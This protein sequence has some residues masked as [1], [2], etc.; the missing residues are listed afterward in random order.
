[1]ADTPPTYDVV[2][3]GTGIAGAILAKELGS[4]GHSV[5]LLEAGVAI[6]NGREALVEKFFLDT[7][8]LPESPFPPNH[9]APT[10]TV[11]DLLDDVRNP[12]KGYLDQSTSKIPFGSSYERRAGGTMWHWMGTSLRL[13]PRDFRMR[14]IY[15]QGVDWPMS[16][17][18]LAIKPRSQHGGMSYYDAA[19]YEIGVAASVDDQKIDEKNLVINPGDVLYR[20]SYGYPMPAIPISTVDQ[21]FK[22]GVRGMTFDGKPVWHYSTPAGRNS[23]PYK[24]RRACA[25]NTNCVP[26]C[27][28]QAKY[29]PTVTLFA[30]LNYQGVFAQFQS[31][32]TRL[33]VKPDGSE[34]EAVEYF[35]YDE[36]REKPVRPPQRAYGRKIVVA[37]HG[38]ETPRLLLLSGAGNKYFKNPHIGKHLMDHPFYI[39]W[40]LAPKPVYPHRGPLSTGGLDGLRDGAFRRDRAAFRIEIGNDGWRLPT[41]DP[42]STVLDLVESNQFGS[43]LVQQLNNILTR[44]VRIGFELEQLPDSQNSVSLSTHRDALGLSRPKINYSISRYEWAG[45]AAAARLTSELFARLK[46]DDKSRDRDISTAGEWQGGKYEFMGAGHIMGTCRMGTDASDSVVDKYQCFHEFPNLFIVGSSVFP[47]GGTANPTLTIAALAFWA[48][49]TISDRLKQ[50]R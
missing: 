13:L 48:A 46:V 35:Q 7:R 10:A 15:G 23:R 45:F 36:S 5:L 21:F 16:Y 30:A 6:P 37:A 11:A 2:I 33:I 28:I 47:T 38:I 20:S 17:D 29:D 1:M 9:H 22:A 43:Q 42:E 3:V 27:P 40:G 12:S 50:D 39:R 31:V 25:G 26:I 4:R 34:I 24:N 19:E 14:T 49:D 18:D 44:Q 8:K 32:A 41:G